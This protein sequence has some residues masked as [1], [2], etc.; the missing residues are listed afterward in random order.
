MLFKPQP[1]YDTKA[2]KHLREK[3]DRFV[4][5]KLSTQR[6][7]TENELYAAGISRDSLQWKYRNYK[8]EEVVELQ[9]EDGPINEK[10]T[11]V[12]TQEQRYGKYR[13]VKRGIPAKV[14]DY[15]NDISTRDLVADIKTF[16]Q[17][18]DH[19]TLVK[20]IVD[21]GI[22]CDDDAREVKKKVVEDLLVKGNAFL[23]AEA[24][25]LT[26]KVKT[27]NKKTDDG[28]YDWSDER[29]EIDYKRGV[30]VR[31]IDPDLVFPEPGACKPT[32]WFIAEPYSYG[33]LIL[34]YPDLEKKVRKPDEVEDT[35]NGD[36]EPKKPKIGP[37]SYFPYKMGEKIKRIYRQGDAKHSEIDL[38]GGWDIGTSWYDKAMC[39]DINSYDD[40]SHGTMMDEASS[41]YHKMNN[42]N[43]Y[44]VW[45]YYNIAYN[46]N[47]S[48]SG[49]YCCV[50]IEDWQLYSGPIQEA[51]K[52]EPIVHLKLHET[53]D[54]WSHSMVDELKDIQDQMN[55][56]ENIKRVNIEYLSSTNFATN[57]TFID[58]SIDI[59]P[60]DINV[61][62]LEEED[63]I[64]AQGAFNVNYS[65]QRMNLGSADAVNLGVSEIQNLLLEMDY[66]YPTVPSKLQYQGEAAQ[67]KTSYS[68]VLAIDDIIEEIGYGYGE[69]AE[70]FVKETAHSI[71]Y[72]VG[73]GKTV[74]LLNK[75]V[76]VVDED[77]DKLIEI[78]ESIRQAQLIRAEQEQKEYEK[79]RQE[80]IQLQSQASQTPQQQPQQSAI[81]QTPNVTQAPQGQPAAPQVPQAPEQQS[82][83]DQIPEKL[84]IPEE[85]EKPI[86][87]A[88][89]A[90]RMLSKAKTSTDGRVYFVYSN[91]LLLGD[92]DLE[93]DI[94]FM[95]TKEE[96]IRDEQE[97]IALMKASGAMIN[98]SYQA[99]RVAN[100]FG[101]SLDVLPINP[102][103]DTQQNLIQ[104]GQAKLN[105]L[106]YPNDRQTDD[107]GTK[108][109]GLAPSHGTFDETEYNVNKELRIIAAKTEAE[110]AIEKSKAEAK[111]GPE[112][113]LQQVKNEGLK[114]NLL[115]QT[116]NVQPISSRRLDVDVNQIPSDITISI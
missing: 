17:D 7:W 61:Q 116:N 65:L 88:K 76:I 109:L 12:W 78:A 26:R 35:S 14:K 51:D 55:A 75:Q 21:K 48:E 60:Y 80:A 31:N 3:R 91:M 108:F 85:L 34:E 39:T 36:K 13:Y 94:K 32:E 37:N 115:N 112:K 10:R 52:K 59:N 5:D 101:K 83:A 6:N 111:R 71:K 33:E 70:K 98:T 77:E 99:E 114:N 86:K 11:R 28:S 69:L 68:P 84:E 1:K 4:A 90:K 93:I 67:E 16:S 19:V 89:Q 106:M 27:W 74:P 63:S 56:H 20:A 103:S 72:L 64:D 62:H 79:L 107:A 24:Y 23:T 38:T 44:W 97:F 22:L 40:R 54:Y 92:M 8:A 105:F 100:M 43:V 102:P 82:I 15:I 95:R 110:I 104:S 96:Q 30:F 41:M 57:K 25:D 113:E 53:D 87:T 46:P 47:D 73:E 18:T 66:L 81:Q 50:F 45:K 58:G 9:T 29:E 2:I 49:D 42:E